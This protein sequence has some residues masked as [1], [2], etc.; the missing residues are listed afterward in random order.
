MSIS[1]FEDNKSVHAVIVE[2]K[3][4]GGIFFITICYG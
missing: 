3:L 2:H 1:L 4:G